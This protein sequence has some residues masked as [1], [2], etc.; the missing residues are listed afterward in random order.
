MN[1][2]QHDIGLGA[3]DSGN[4]VGDRT[5]LADEIDQRTQ[6]GAHTGAEHRVVI[7]EVHPRLLRAHSLTTL[8]FALA[9]DFIAAC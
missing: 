5:G 4:G 7:D 2:E 6:L 1:V 9:R 3:H 8:S